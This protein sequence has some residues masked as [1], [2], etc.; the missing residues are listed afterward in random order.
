MASKNKTFWS[1]LVSKTD[2]HTEQAEETDDILSKIDHNV[3]NR[4]K[5]YHAHATYESV[6]QHN[7]V[8]YEEP[9]RGRQRSRTDYEGSAKAQ[10]PP[11]PVSKSQAAYANYQPMQSGVY[12]G[13]SSSAP[14]PQ[15]NYH[16]HHQQY[17]A[18][19]QQGSQ[20]QYHQ[21]IH[22]A[23]KHLPQQQPQ[24]QQ[25][26]MMNS[27]QYSADTK[28]PS[29]QG[30]RDSVTSST[31]ST[32]NDSIDQSVV[33]SP[34][35]TA[36]LA[37]KEQPEEQSSKPASPKSAKEVVYQINSAQDNNVEFE[38]TLALS[39]HLS[40]L[41]STGDFSDVTL[42]VS[43]TDYKLHRSILSRA[44]FFKKL[45]QS[46][47][48]SV[49]SVSIEDQRVTVPAVEVVFRYIYGS[50]IVISNTEDSFDE[51]DGVFRVK[52]NDVLS[53]LATSCHFMMKEL[54]DLCLSFITTVH[55]APH[56]QRILSKEDYPEFCS[57]DPIPSESL[58]HYIDFVD[59]SDYGQI[60]EH[61]EDALLNY[62]CTEGYSSLEDA[63][64]RIPLSWLGRVLEADSFWCPTE[65]ARYKFAKS[66]ILKRK[67]VENGSVE[68]NEAM[69][70][71][72]FRYAIIY[73]HMTFEELNEVKDDGFIPE[74]ILMTALWKQTRFKSEIENA[75][76]NK[77]AFDASDDDPWARS[78]TTPVS[79]G[80]KTP[81]N[82]PVSE[83]AIASPIRIGVE[84]KEF[85]D[86]AE[87]ERCY[88]RTFF[89]GGSW[90]SAF[91]QR[92]PASEDGSKK[93]AQKWGIFLRRSDGVTI[94]QLALSESSATAGQIVT[95]PL[96]GSEIVRSVTYYTDRR[97]TARAVFKLYNPTVKSY[98]PVFESKINGYQTTQSWGYRSREHVVTEKDLKVADIDESA[99]R[100]RITLIMKYL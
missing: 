79:D 53:L 7:Q 82:N 20:Q 86:L 99:A 23:T 4:S 87:N 88:S 6:S 17:H 60:T 8:V 76:E 90:W 67:A 92:F 66:I 98:E 52:S 38:Q 9:E 62:L 45:L 93:N 57:M 18:Q 81:P 89:Y 69:Y 84:F 28:R 37:M 100:I 77:E 91:L 42:K 19:Q 29:V 70:K 1:R 64:T 61:V 32:R 54:V 50:K 39:E 27:R 56:H 74:T 13:S 71:E 72:I 78:A 46:N 35:S 2:K 40:V 83:V 96:T 97:K 21:M 16:A 58:L 41:F 73:S 12:Y 24:Q 47:K 26:Q 11:V 34:G 44:P 94:H 33:V 30:V 15:M 75:P 3:Q 25:Q 10:M 31:S 59:N 55:I 80:I 49:I 5:G 48:S 85:K 68:N 95:D 65:F 36:R 14:P 22:A 63:F 51:Y 43:N